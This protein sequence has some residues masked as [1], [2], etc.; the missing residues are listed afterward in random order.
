MATG[1]LLYFSSRDPDMRVQLSGVA[2]AP[3]GSDYGQGQWTQ[4]CDEPILKPELP[5]EGECIEAAALCRH[6]GRL[7]MFYGG[8]YNNAPQQVGCAVSDDGVHWERVSDEPI[9]PNGAPGEWNHSES[10]HPFVFEAS[11]GRY[12]LFF[13]GNNDKGKTWYLSRKEIT[14]Q[15][16]MP[17]VEA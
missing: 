7:Y 15:D 8:A 17:V 14:W 6:D 4:L 5:W 2:A 9:L 16:G 12:H 13:Q 1:L 10:G 11:D 3:L